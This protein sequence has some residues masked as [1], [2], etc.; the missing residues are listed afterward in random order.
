MAVA[1]DKMFMQML[2]CRRWCC[3]WFWLVMVGWEMGLLDSGGLNLKV[4]PGLAV[5]V[6]RHRLLVRAMPQ[7][8]QCTESGLVPNSCRRDQ[9][10][11]RE[12]YRGGQPRGRKGKY[13]R[14]VRS[15]GPS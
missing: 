10:R 2:R 15:R 7:E 14:Y 13:N 3:Y 5:A 1:L 4:V 8:C 9:E 11:P 12:S 6:V